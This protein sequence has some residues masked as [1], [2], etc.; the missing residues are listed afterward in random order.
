MAYNIIDVV[1]DLVTGNLKFVTRTVANERYTKCINCDVFNSKLNNCTICGC[2][3]PIKTKL[4]K[5][6][7]PMEIW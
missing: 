2:Y 6:T 5:S 1:K 3:M 7:C 4:E